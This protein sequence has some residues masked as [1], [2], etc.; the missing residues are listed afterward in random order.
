MTR[1]IIKLLIKSESPVREFREKFTLV[2]DY[3]TFLSTISYSTQNVVHKTSCDVVTLDSQPTQAMTS[4][5][6][7]VEYEIIIRKFRNLGARNNH[8]DLGVRTRVAGL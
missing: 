7:L 4:H 6:V 5:D 2:R 1:P 3:E 8:T